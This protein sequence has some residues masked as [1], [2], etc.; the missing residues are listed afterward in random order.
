VKVGPI[1]SSVLVYAA[2]GADV[3]ASALQSGV[4]PRPAASDATAEPPSGLGLLITGAVFSGIA[5]VNLVTSP[6]CATDFVSD[7]N[8]GLCWGVQLGV[9]GAFAAVGLPLLVIGANQNAHHSEWVLMH[10]QGTAWSVTPVAGGAV[11]SMT[12][13][14]D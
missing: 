13:P 5:A 10:S 4:A 7:S 2:W 1:V 8:R 3:T 14:T 6:L 11:V 12:V 9:V